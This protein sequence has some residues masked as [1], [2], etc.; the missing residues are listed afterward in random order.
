MARHRSFRLVEKMAV[1]FFL[2]Q[3]VLRVG[4]AGAQT[5]AAFRQRVAVRDNPASRLDLRTVT[6]RPTPFAWLRDPV[7]LPRVTGSGTGADATYP[8]TNAVI[9]IGTGATLGAAIGGLIV[10]AN[11]AGDEGTY[12]RNRWSYVGSTMAGVALGTII[13]ITDPYLFGQDPDAG[14]ST[15]MALFGGVWVAT[16]VAYL[17]DPD[18]QGGNVGSFGRASF[19]ATWIGAVGFGLWADL[20]TKPGTAPAGSALLTMRHGSFPRLAIPEVRI[21]HNTAERPGVSVE[22]G[23]VRF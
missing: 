14:L 10:L 8:Y 21:T 19:F 7:S 15:F 20:K 13:H 23:S 9:A 1:A 17:V 16:A 22:L 4:D 6:G 12:D 18:P 5:D 11:E 2:G 3:A